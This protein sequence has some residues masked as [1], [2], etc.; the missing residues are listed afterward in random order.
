MKYK[1]V[2]DEIFLIYDNLD[3]LQVYG[4]SEKKYV[5]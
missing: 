4:L 5:T 2:I 1:Y 3:L